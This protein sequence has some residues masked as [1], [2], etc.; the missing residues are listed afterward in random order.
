MYKKLLS[1]AVTISMITGLSPSV[2]LAQEAESD[3][4]IQTIDTMEIDDEVIASGTCG[5]SATWELTKG[6][7]LTISGSGS[8]TS[9]AAAKSAPWYS[10]MDSIT[11]VVINEGI[12]SIS[13]Y[14]FNGYEKI[15]SV[16]L[17]EGIKSIGKYA[18]GDCSSLTNIILPDTVTSI[19]TYAF[20]GCT[21]L[22]SKNIPQG[23]TSIGTDTFYNFSSLKQIV[24]PDSVTSIGLKAF[25]GCTSLETVTFSENLKSIDQSAFSGCSS[26]ASVYLP[27][28]LTSIGSGAFSDCIALTNVT[29]SASLTLID[30]NTFNNCS[31]LESITIPAG[32]GQ[33]SG[34]AFYKCTSLKSLTFEDDS[35][36][37]SISSYAFYNC[38][39]LE[40]LNLPDS[41]TT[42][43]DSA[44]A[45]DT[46]LQT[47]YLSK[48]LTSLGIKVFQGC[49]SLESIAFPESLTS[50]P[51]YTFDG[52]S[53]LSEVT[54]TKYIVSIGDYAF[55]SCTSL[56]DLTFSEGLETIGQYA[57][58]ACTGLTT[59]TLPASLTA[60]DAYAFGSCSSLTTINFSEGL[61]TIG[62]NAFE[63]CGL[64]KLYFPSTVTLIDQYAFQYNAD[65][66]RVEL[67][68]NENL[69]INTGAFNECTSL[70]DLYYPISYSSGN[71]TGRTFVDTAVT[72]IWTD[73]E[74]EDAFWDYI[75]ELGIIKSEPF[76]HDPLTIHIGYDHIVLDTTV[77][78]ETI[79]T[80][81]KLNE[82]DYTSVSWETLAPAMEES[83][84]ILT[85][86]QMTQG[87]ITNAAETL[88]EVMDSLVY[89]ADLKSLFAEAQELDQNNYQP[90]TWTLF[91]TALNSAAAVL[92]NDEATQDEVDDA[93]DTLT[94]GMKQLEEKIVITSD[95]VSAIP[96]QEY[97]GSQITPSVSVNHEGQVLSKGLS[98]KVS[99][100]ENISGEGY[101][102]ITGNGN[103]TGE[104]I[105]YFTIV[106]ADKSALQKAFE[107]AKS[108]DTTDATDETKQAL[109]D[110]M[111]EAEAVINNENATSSDIDNALKDLE[112]AITGLVFD[113]SNSSK[114]DVSEINDQT[115][116]GSQITPNVTATYDDTDLV[117]GTDYTVAYGDNVNVGTGTITITGQGSYT[118]T[119]EITFNIISSSSG[120][121]PSD[122]GNDDEG[123]GSENGTDIP[124]DN[125]GTD[126]NNGT[127]TGNSGT[128]DNSTNTGAD[129][130]NGNSTDPDENNG[131]TGSGSGEDNN[132]ADDNNGTGTGTDENTGN[133]EGESGA[134]NSDSESGGTDEN[135]DSENSDES[136]G[137]DSD[138]TDDGAS[139]NDG[140]GEGEDVLNPEDGNEDAVISPDK[141]ALEDA[142]DAASE[143][144]NEGNSGSYWD[145]LEDAV[146]KAKDVLNDENATSEDISDALDAISKAAE[147]LTSLFDDVYTKTDDN[148]WYF[149][150]VYDLVDRGAITGYGTESDLFGVGNS[151]TRADFVTLV[152]RIM[153]P[154]Q[155]STYAVVTAQNTSEFPDVEDG[156]YYTEAVCWA[157]ENGYITGYTQ[158]DTPIFDPDQAI[159][160]EQAVAILSRI[161]IGY[162][163]T[164]SYDSDILSSEMFTDGTDV[165]QWAQSSM[166]WAID[167]GLVTGHDNNDG[168]FNISPATA[169][170]RERLVTV[171][172][173]ALQAGYLEA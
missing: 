43:G 141:S 120:D 166:S 143:L 15:T 53:S 101:V 171:I 142:I 39:S 164:Q 17:S 146:N 167:S 41:V 1:A 163:S 57:F 20:Y 129:D 9:F 56:T 131:N 87:A 84:T 52:C 96:D 133:A 126:E 108:I 62:K 13:G 115:Y 105:V 94:A 121:D 21:K 137:S 90:K 25:Y 67:P 165:A 89:I 109:E 30:T 71:I 40:S 38:T 153:C 8:M 132:G 147:S 152:W 72:D 12:T 93:I 102:I 78:T 88:Q 64:L 158:Y 124:D 107:E 154:T 29:L 63:Y 54:W 26:L 10:Y 55:R 170:E 74:S 139:G 19:D 47:V 151:R 140:D 3:Y 79:E 42:I 118:G 145:N 60:I 91:T 36:L 162:E 128:D 159:S 157:L 2:A 117:E 130:N 81:E 98:Y 168:T 44:F 69:V 23:I 99:Y 31:S 113:I 97:T 106:G 68:I 66:Y 4:S 32:I 70:S 136:N 144:I 61:E 59:I 169:V 160:F 127:D 148:S 114:L 155:Y 161:A 33:I 86:T 85:E 76:T 104:V 51:N 77:L 123:D 82:E 7:T 18:F 112:D 135:T 119:V 125:N 138:I 73:A 134:V 83:E 6:G 100:G 150:A 103:Y 24:L 37:A 27:D 22:A 11:S 14:A 92:D 65:L 46:S 50:I 48:N 122:S 156:A 80:A 172:Y 28:S 16:T 110:A 34:N 45:G 111:S 75:N 49:T 116:S 149:D 5:T 173:R 58:N 95:D 35:Q